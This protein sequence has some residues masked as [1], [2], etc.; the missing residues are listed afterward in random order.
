MRSGSAL[1]CAAAYVGLHAL[2]I[3]AFPRASVALSY[4]FMFLAT[5]LALVACVGWVVRS[6]ASLRLCGTLVACGLALWS[7]GLLLDAWEEVI[8]HNTATVALI[9]DLLYFFYGVPV[10][11][12]ISSSSAEQRSQLFLWLYALQATVIAYLAYTLLFSG[13]PFTGEHAAPITADR[14]SQA[15]LVENIVLAAAAVVRLFAC[16]DF[17]ERRFYRIVCAFLWVY[18]GASSLYNFSYGAATAGTGL[19][20]VIIDVPFLMLALW[21]AYAPQYVADRGEQAPKGPVALFIAS[22]SPIFFT[23]GILALGTVVMQRHFAAGSA[24]VGIALACYGLQATLLQNRYIRSQHS[25]REALDRLQGLS[26]TD[27]LTGIA[28]RRC[29]DQSLE[30]EWSRAKRSG[31]SLSLLMIDIDFFKLLNDRYGHVGGDECLKTIAHTLRAAL[32]RDTDVLARYGGEE[33]AAILPDTDRQGAETVAGKMRAAVRRLAIRNET[34]MGDVATISVGV[35]T[36]DASVNASCVDLIKGSDHALYQ[37][38]QG[39]RDRIE[40]YSIA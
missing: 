25:L 34:P 38:K 18:L 14:L 4:A 17:E 6:S 40:F 13:L 26:M 23:F 11:L 27:S 29:F 22:A 37:A 9:P 33:F 5:I 31:K 15:F 21:F 1:V 30:R 20:D 36:S 28:N 10:L 19:E 35:T 39:G 16:E 2:C 24:G 12:A 8:K 32:P 7:G 3:V